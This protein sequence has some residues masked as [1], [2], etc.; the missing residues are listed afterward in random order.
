M[1]AVRLGMA[2]RYQIAPVGGRLMDVDHLQSGELLSPLRR[3]PPARIPRRTDFSGLVLDQVVALDQE[4][5]IVLERLDREVR[6]VGHVEL[7]AVR[8]V[9]IR[10]R[11]RAACGGP[12]GP[13]R[14]SS[15]RGPQRCRRRRRRGGRAWTG[16]PRANDAGRVQADGCVSLCALTGVPGF[17]SEGETSSPDGVPC[18]QA[19]RSA[20]LPLRT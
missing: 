11:A 16:P 14:R 13:R 8:P 15:P 19:R 9:R 4:G 1:L 17:R 6:R 20:H 3:S 2:R 12:S 7:H 18:A 10:L 5:I